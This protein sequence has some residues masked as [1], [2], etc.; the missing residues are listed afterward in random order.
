MTYISLYKIYKEV[1][2]FFGKI[3]VVSVENFIKKAKKYQHKYL[4]HIIVRDTG[5]DTPEDPGMD[6]SDDDDR[7]PQHQERKGGGEVLIV[8]LDSDDSDNGQGERQAILAPSR[9]KGG[10]TVS[11]KPGP[12]RGKPRSQPSMSKK[13]KKYIDPIVMGREVFQ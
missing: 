4:R 2:I 8:K 5:E 1:I 3:P 12:S 10:L 11:G 9:P 7:K 13:E 6:D